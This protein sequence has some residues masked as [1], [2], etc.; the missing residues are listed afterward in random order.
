MVFHYLRNEHGIKDNHKRVYRL[1]KQAGL[2]LRLPPRRSR[3]RREYQELLAPEQINQGWAMDFVSDWVIGPQKQSVRIINVMDEASRRALWTEAH[4][5]ISASKLI[6]IL[7]KLIEWRGVPQYIRCDNG[8]EF[9][10]QHLALWAEKHQV[11]LRF[12]QA[13]KPSQNGLIERLNKT[14]RTE[15]LNLHWFTSMKELNE[16]IQEWSVVYNHLRPHKNIGY[17]PPITFE[18]SNKVFYSRVVAA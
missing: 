15:C 16:N 10:S 2:H 1:W 4:E 9:I 7:D 12:I 14:L 11:E 8:P 6:E 13:G 3:I 17:Q 5:R 18:N